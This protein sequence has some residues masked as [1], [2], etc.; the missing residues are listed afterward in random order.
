MWLFRSRKI[1]SH[2]AGKTVWITGASSGIGA[3]LAVD[4]AS[5]GAHL[6]LSAR[7]TDRLDQVRGACDHPERHWVVPLD[8]SDQSRLAAAARTVL[9][10]CPVDILIHNA[11]I[12]QRS[13]ALDTDS[14]V[15]RQLLEVNTLGTVALN[16]AVVPSMV[17]SGGGQVVVIT[18]ILGRIGIPMR[19]AYAASK[20]ALHGYFECLRAEVYKKGIG[21]TLICP[22][23][24]D[25]EISLHALMADGRPHGKPSQGQQKGVSPTLCA[26]EIGNAIARRRPEALVG[27][28]ETWAVLLFRWFPWLFRRLSRRRLV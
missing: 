21:V 27:G 16:S 13:L 15:V 17:E 28:T 14:Q 1:K 24:V 5:R 4:L 2:F 20:H 25:T 11:G 12:S 23:F 22:G 6:V 26:R 10:K 18:S 8:L 3:A 19:S 9:K 7:R